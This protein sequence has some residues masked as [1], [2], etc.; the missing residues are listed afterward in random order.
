MALAHITDL[1]E[2]AKARMLLQYKTLAK[3]VGDVAVLVAEV[4]ELEDAFWAFYLEL[5]VELADGVW[6]DRLG[7]LIGERRES[8]GDTRFRNFIKARI[9]ANKSTGSTDDVL[10]VA[11]QAL[12]EF[13][14]SLALVDWYPAA[15]ALTVGSG[16]PLGG[17]NGDLV[18]NRL[19]RILGRARA[20]A[21]QL[22]V[23]YQDDASDAAIFVCG[24]ALGSDP[25]GKG[26]DSA[27]APNDPAAGRLAGALN[28]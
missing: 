15:E 1:V 10:A 7:S 8:A 5:D 17:Q 20:I 12:A 18:L 22:G 24:D 26:F 23:L 27:S 6:L 21:V 3:F 11:A 16:T 2:Q 19:V 14:P 25:T 4:Q 13:A 9:L 28:T